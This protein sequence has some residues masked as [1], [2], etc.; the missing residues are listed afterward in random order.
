MTPW[1]YKLWFY[2]RRGNFNG[3]KFKR[4]V[5][6]EKYIADFC[7]NDKKLI[8]ELDGNQH[9]SSVSDKERDKFFIDLGYKILRF[10]NNEI[11]LN[12]DGVLEIIRKNL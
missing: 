11:N 10:W 1:E 9:R 4:Q 7:C 2:L 8:I 6:V 3:I 12:I 5:P